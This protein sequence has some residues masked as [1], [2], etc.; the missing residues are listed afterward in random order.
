MRASSK[1][2][3]SQASVSDRVRE[4]T[5]ASTSKRV[6]QNQ[7]RNCGF[8]TSSEAAYFSLPRMKMFK[9]S[10]MLPL[11][12][13]FWGRFFFNT[14]WPAG[15]KHKTRKCLLR[16]VEGLR[17]TARKFAAKCE[18]FVLSLGAFVAKCEGFARGPGGI[19]R[20]VRRIR[21]KFR[22]ICH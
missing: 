11:R 4:G 10:P 14:C 5:A 13:G 20:K 9:K 2:S 16:N 17:N 21:P 18:M 12:L 8:A 1:L 6:R 19:C 15:R 22:N 7:E 3:F